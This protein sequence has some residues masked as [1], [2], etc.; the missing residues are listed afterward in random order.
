ML[1]SR[2][3]ILPMPLL[4]LLPAASRKSRFAS[5]AAA[6]SATER[7]TG[8]RCG[9]ALLDIASGA[10]FSVRGDERFAMC[11]TFKLPLV[12]QLLHAA[13]Q[14]KVQLDEALP[15]GAED[16]VSHAPFTQPRI[17][18]TLTLLELA[19]AAM[20]SSDNPATNLILR[21]LG[22]PAGFTAWIRA[23]G[24]TVTRLD[25]YEVMMSEGTPGDVRDTTS[26]NAMLDLVRPILTGNALSLESRRRLVDWMHASETGNDM[27]RS[28]LPNGWREG[29]KTGSGNHGIRNTISII[30][31]PTEKALQA[32][33]LVCIYMAGV[34][35]TLAERNAHYPPLARALVQAI[36][37]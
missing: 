15:I 20:T 1:S 6:L 31:A 26:P 13:E 25:R 36:T 2:R 16:M 23:R 29:N 33:V 14:G 4:A 10:R 30:S 22:G 9:L 35:A 32:P 19:S 3:A 7:T 5:V 34:G 8:G 12:A 18:Q 37:A 27:L 17:G 24:D 11:S 28:G 21:R